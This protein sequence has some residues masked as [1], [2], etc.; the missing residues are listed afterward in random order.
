M[1]VGWGG[2]DCNM[3]VTQRCVSDVCIEMSSVGDS[4]FYIMIKVTNSPKVHNYSKHYV[5]NNRAS[6]Y[7]KQKRSNRN[8]RRNLRRN[9]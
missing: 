1:L 8:L 6:N 3:M 7:M 4:F 2:L 9:S 5:A